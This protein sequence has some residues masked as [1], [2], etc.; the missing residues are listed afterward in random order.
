MSHFQ[1]NKNIKSDIFKLIL[2]W[3]INSVPRKEP[4][5]KQTNIIADLCNLTIDDFY[6]CSICLGPAIL[7]NIIKPCK[8]IFCL[9][10]I[11]ISMKTSRKCPLCRG[12]IQ[13]INKI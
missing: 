12:I 7:R 9:L 5:F 1:E 13:S 2:P 11:K 10:C 3:F 6:D 8:H 4:I